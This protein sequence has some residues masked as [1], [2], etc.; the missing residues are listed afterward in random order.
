MKFGFIW[1][2]RWAPSGTGSNGVDRKILKERHHHY[3]HKYMWHFGRRGNVDDHVRKRQ[4]RRR[5]NS[6]AQPSRIRPRRP[7]ANKP[8][9]AQGQGTHAITLST[10]G[11]D[12]RSQGSN[13]PRT[14]INFNKRGT[15]SKLLKCLP[16]GDYGRPCIW[17]TISY[18]HLHCEAVG[19][20]ND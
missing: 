9:E 3:D 7:T 10:N 15:S 5:V 17:I 20:N 6:F 12:S 8:C 1:C 13:R 11:I 14:Q 18:C 19:T 4:T 2:E 16:R